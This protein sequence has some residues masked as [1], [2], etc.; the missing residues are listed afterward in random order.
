M[1]IFNE[2][3]NLFTPMSYT[4]WLWVPV[5][6]L[7]GAFAVWQLSGYDAKAYRNLSEIRK[8]FLIS[9]ILSV[10]WILFWH[11]KRP[12]ISFIF[13]VLLLLITS[14]LINM[15]ERMARGR[16]GVAWLKIGFSLSL[17]LVTM[18]TV[19]N[20]AAM[21]QSIKP[22]T[23]ASQLFTVLFLA[24]ATLLG[25]IF[26]V[27]MRDFFYGVSMVWGLFGVFLNHILVFKLQYLVVVIVALLM[28]FIMLA[29]LVSLIQG[30]LRRNQSNKNKPPQ[31]KRRTKKTGNTK[32][33]DTFDGDT[34]RYE[35]SGNE[36][37]REDGYASESY[38][39]N[40]TPEGEPPTH[41]TP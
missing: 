33:N 35:D 17:G 32:E 16:K 39:E 27:G 12:I 11:L 13:A 14:M 28:V 25:L 29:S 19:G 10:L 34:K 30:N 4:A 3:P 23:G 9:N 26:T 21:I 37:Y 6:L 5:I 15:V 18:L 1:E 20:L 8:F 7:L 36:G 31:P 2:F 38:K 22:E 41:P 24:L 40:A